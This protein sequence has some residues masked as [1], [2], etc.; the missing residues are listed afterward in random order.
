MELTLVPSLL[1]LFIPLPLAPRQGLIVRL[2]Q[3]SP[4]PS[5]LPPPPLRK[6]QVYDSGF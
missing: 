1:Q 4:I 6:C 3:V 5:L 2:S